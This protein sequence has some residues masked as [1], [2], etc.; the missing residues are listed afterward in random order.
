VS[1]LEV[2]SEKRLQQLL[3]LIPQLSESQNLFVEVLN[4][5]LQSLIG[6]PW[7]VSKALCRLFA[8]RKA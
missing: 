4:Q 2:R 5:Q 3:L 1:H 7:Q 8:P 6:R